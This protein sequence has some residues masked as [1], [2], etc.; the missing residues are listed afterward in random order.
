MG[1]MYCWWG[2]VLD[3]LRVS[4]LKGESRTDQVCCRTGARAFAILT[5][6]SV[7]FFAAKKQARKCP[8]NGLHR[9]CYTRR[10]LFQQRDQT[11]VGS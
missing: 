2:L 5:A 11:K 10:E 6:S 8:D 7:S 9:R 1:G 4:G 3:G